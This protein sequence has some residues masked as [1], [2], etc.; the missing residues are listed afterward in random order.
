VEEFRS[1]RSDSSWQ[2]WNLIVFQVW[3]KKYMAGNQ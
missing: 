1:R 2:L 3:H